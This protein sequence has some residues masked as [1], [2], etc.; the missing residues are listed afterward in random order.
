MNN[1]H[2]I[3]GSLGRDPFQ[4]ERRRT[5]PEPGGDSPLNIPNIPLRK[6]L[7]ALINVYR[8]AGLPEAPAR[9]AALADLECDFGSLALA[10]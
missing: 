4:A 2:E 9:K 8:E 7:Q 10:A 1:N 5:A 6:M 3:I